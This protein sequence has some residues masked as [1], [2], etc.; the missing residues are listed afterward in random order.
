MSQAEGGKALGFWDS[1]HWYD[2]KADA[3]AVTLAAA[4][5]EKLTRGDMPHVSAQPGDL[6]WRKTV[7]K[8]RGAKMLLRTIGGV[9][10]IGIWMGELNQYFT[11][12]CP[13]PADKK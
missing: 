6:Y 5:S 1:G 10:V 2:H 12:W 9:A 7:P 3:L 4:E 8:Y 13:L 11:G